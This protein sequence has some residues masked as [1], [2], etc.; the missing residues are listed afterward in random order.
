MAVELTDEIK[1]QV[2][3]EATEVTPNF[4]IDP[5][6]ARLGKVESDKA[7]ALDEN[8]E[9]YGGMIAKS[10]SFYDAQIKASQEWADKQTQ[11]QQEQSDFAIEQIEQK[12]DQAHKDYLKE[13]SGAYVDWQKQSNKYGIEAERQAS[14][15]LTGTGFAESSQVSMYNTYQNRLATAREGYNKAVLNYD[16]AIKDAMLQNNAKLAEI[17]YAALEKQLELSVQGFQYKNDLVIQQANKKLEIKNMFHNQYMDVLDQINH[18]NDVKRDIWKHKDT[19][20]WQT[21]QAQIERDFKAGENEKQRTFEAGEN[22]KQRK[23]EAQE[24]VLERDFKAKQAEIERKHDLDLVKANTEAA[25]EKADHEY[26]LAM[27]KLEQE[28]ENDLAILKQ[29]L[30]NDKSLASYKNSLE[31]Q[32]QSAPISTKRTVSNTTVNGKQ[33]SK[34]AVVGGRYKAAVNNQQK[35]QTTT[36]PVN[37]ASVMALGYGAVSNEKLAKLVANGQVE[38]Y[39][40]NGQTYFKKASPTSNY[41]YRLGK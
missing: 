32:T 28:H 9:L 35:K 17:A 22:E 5:N 13:Q 29:E 36:Y 37:K 16:N 1:Q 7:D 15:G 12:K 11:L 6:D 19:Q 27:K 10:D 20:K 8:A 34:N 18:E 38:M 26:E 30:A 21:E 25:K 33:Y 39:V 23:F 3:D 14:A 40:K 24:A 31:K 4:D 41:K 2:L